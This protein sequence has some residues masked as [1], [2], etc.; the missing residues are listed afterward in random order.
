L[1]YQIALCAAGVILG[2]TA[3]DPLLAQPVPPPYPPSY[4]GPY[5]GSPGGLPPHEIVTIVRSTGLEPLGRPVRQGPT[6]ALRAVDPA[7]R[8]VHVLVDARMGR[9]LRVVPAVRQGG[10][11]PPTP[12]PPGRIVPDGNDPNSRMADFPYGT[13]EVPPGWPGSPAAAPG[14]P[15]AKAGP[16]PLPRPRPKT[17][18]AAE[19]ASSSPGNPAAPPRFEMDE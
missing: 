9:I 12:I 5:P 10:M 19:P 3:C 14:R 2:L 17:A 6:Y 11:S 4:P 15:G 13:D 1:K 16:P 18:S 8:E 7:G